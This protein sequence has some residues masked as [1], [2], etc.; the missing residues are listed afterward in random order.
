M[1]FFPDMPEST[2][3]GGYMKLVKGENKFRIL[4]PGVAGFEWWITTPEGKRQPMRARLNERP[5]N[6]ELPLDPET[7]N[8][9]SLKIFLAMPVWNYA[10]EQVQILE[11]TQATIR[12]T[13][14][15]LETDEDWGTPLEYD[16]KI[17]REGDGRDTTYSVSPSPKKAAPKV[18]LEAYAEMQLNLDALFDGDNPFAES[19]F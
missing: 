13:M 10:E 12:K 17:T 9:V 14:K 8:P 5:N 18:A 11:V 16:L 2:A 7:G 6:S 1:G 3:Q 19:S 15:S 4:G